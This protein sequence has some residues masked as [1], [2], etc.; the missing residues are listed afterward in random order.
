MTTKRRCAIYTRKSSEEGLEQSF[1]SLDAQREACSAYVLSQAGEG[2]S[3]IPK[4]Y[5]D[6]GYSGGSVDRPGLQELLR[7]IQAGRIDVVVVYKVDR[8]TRSLP[9]FAKIVDVLDA[10][11]ASFVSV[12]QAFNTTTSMGRLTLNVL[13]SFAQFE[14]EVT[15]ERIRD[16]LAASKAKGMWMGGSLPIG[17]DVQDRRLIV[18]HDEA[19]IVRFAFQ[20]YL[21]QPGVYEVL[22]TLEANGY[23]SKHWTS[24]S[25]KAHGGMKF[26]RGAIYYLLRNRLYLGEIEHHGAIHPG[27]HDP[28]VDRETFQR[29]QEKL[30][31]NAQADRATTS[32]SKAHALLGLLFDDRGNAMTGTHANKGGR[33]YFYYVSTAANVGDHARAGSLTRV[34]TPTIETA[35]REIVFPIL[36]RDWNNEVEASQRV[37]DSL[38][39]VTIGE[40]SISIELKPDAIDADAAP[41]LTRAEDTDHLIL[42]RDVQLV[43]R[44][45]AHVLSVDGKAATQPSRVDRALVRSVVLAKRWMAM[46]NSGEA[47]SIDALARQEHLCPRNTARVLP[48]AFLAPDLVEMIL[49]GQQPTTLTLSK[50]LD[51]CLPYAWSEQRALFADFA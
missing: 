19:Q 33:R 4:A 43:R 34:S 18:N 16:K 26:S 10:A 46:L 15:A 14:R 17:Y 23:R 49:A 12:T 38:S 42:T 40:K 8:L 6:G 47:P 45:T 1:N 32:K 29:V 36:R 41:A 51:A 25:G 9:D 39:R 7:D 11:G 2:W 30:H 37:I 24:K 27:L 31:A 3:L 50:L 44:S 22:A 5:D 21:E 20:T 35:L 28:I 48:L 13:L